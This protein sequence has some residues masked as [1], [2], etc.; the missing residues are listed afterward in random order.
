MADST[1]EEITRL[2]SMLGPVVEA[3]LSSGEVTNERAAAL[4]EIMADFERARALPDLED[5][6]IEMKKVMARM[7]A[8][9][10]PEIR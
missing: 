4:R 10:M 1:D 7:N 9:F 2:W 8:T 3:R 6:V 5:R